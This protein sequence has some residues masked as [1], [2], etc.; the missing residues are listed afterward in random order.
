MAADVVGVI[1]AIRSQLVLHRDVVDVD[2]GHLKQNARCRM[3]FQERVRGD[4][5]ADAVES[6]ADILALIDRV[7]GGAV[8][9]R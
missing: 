3:P 5:A 9:Q 7:D 1:F 6:E 4:N 2:R 8:R